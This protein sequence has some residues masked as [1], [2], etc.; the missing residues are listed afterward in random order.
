[1]SSRRNS[2]SFTEVNS[3]ATTDRLTIT[4]RYRCPFWSVTVPTTWS[5]AASAPG[6]ERFHVTVIEHNPGDASVGG[7]GGRVLAERLLERGQF[8]DDDVR[9]ALELLL[10]GP[11]GAGHEELVQLVHLERGSGAEDADQV[12]DGQADEQ[13]VASVVKA[14]GEIHR[15]RSTLRAEVLAAT[16]VGDCESEQPS[17]RTPARIGSSS[18]GRGIKTSKHEES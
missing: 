2:K 8:D 7:H 6:P 3:G 11:I 15:A 9:L 16:A 18:Q 14:G 10:R 1:M 5:I 13:D 4:S 12:L 17:A